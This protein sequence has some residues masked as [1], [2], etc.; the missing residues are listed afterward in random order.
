MIKYEITFN[1]TYA[2]SCHLISKVVKGN[3]LYIDNNMKVVV[4]NNVEVAKYNEINNIRFMVNGYYQTIEVNPNG[5]IEP[6]DI[7]MKGG[8]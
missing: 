2:H 1:K 7:I 4:I 8:E 5:I 3:D 6:T